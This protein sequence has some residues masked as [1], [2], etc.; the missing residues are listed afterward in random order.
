M[1][2]HLFV[3][4]TWNFAPH[5]AQRFAPLEL[6]NVHFG[7]CILPKASDLHGAFPAALVLLSD[8]RYKGGKQLRF[9]LDE[10]QDEIY[11]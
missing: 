2:S 8:N 11:T 9:G 10:I 3:V 7:Q 1:L 4:F 5:I 6:I